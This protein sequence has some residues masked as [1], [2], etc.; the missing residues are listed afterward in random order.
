MSTGA[1]RLTLLDSDIDVN[2]PNCKYP[3]WVR[4]AEVVARC[5]VICPACRC[6]V[7][8]RDGDGSV[9]NAATDMQ[10]AVDDLM[11]TLGG[12]FK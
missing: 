6:Q 1:F 12:M 4:L 3:I 5:A 2:C 9:Q 7:W 11:R 8:L 10:N